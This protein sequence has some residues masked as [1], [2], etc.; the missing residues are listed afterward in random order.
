V[1]V[2]KYRDPVSGLFVPL[3]VGGGGMDQ[4]TGDARY[5]NIGGDAMTGGLGFGSVAVATPA[6]LSRHLALYST[7]YGISVSASAMNYMTS[8]AA[9]HYFRDSTGALNEIVI[10]DGTAANEAASKGQMDQGYTSVLSGSSGWID[11]GGAFAGAYVSRSGPIV[12]VEAMMKRSSNLT[13]AVSTLYPVATLPSPA[14]YPGHTVDAPCMYKCTGSTNAAGSPGR[15]QIDASGGIGFIATVAGTVNTGDW[16][17]I[18]VVY[19]PA[20]L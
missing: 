8:T 6:D 5:V 9:K 14:W 3:S 10:A 7:T 12:A 20:T 11:Y 18:N 17:N 13:V 4:A 1:S 16:V 19:R 2:L 15:I